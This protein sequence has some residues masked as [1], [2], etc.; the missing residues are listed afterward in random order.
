MA[1]VPLDLLDRIRALE[2]QVRALMGSAN[3]R[4][5]APPVPAVVPPARLALPP[6][7]NDGRDLPT[8]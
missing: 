6:A 8:D 2:R 7:P 1:A 5:T 3:T 4:R